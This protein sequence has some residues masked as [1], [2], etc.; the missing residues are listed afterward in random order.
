MPKYFLRDTPLAEFERMM[1]EPPGPEWRS[2]QQD[3]ERTNR[4]QHRQVEAACPRIQER[5]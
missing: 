5:M 4:D 1:M 3:E 2:D